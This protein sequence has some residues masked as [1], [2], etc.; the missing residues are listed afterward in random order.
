MKT[1]R[2]EKLFLLGICLCFCS[3]A[4]ANDT[5][6]DELFMWFA[7][8]SVEEAT[9]LAEQNPDTVEKDLE[10]AKELFAKAEIE[11]TTSNTEYLIPENTT[12]EVPNNE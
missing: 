6:D 12:S 9:L 11:T 1:S 8:L 4:S 7:E 3:A 10:S 5:S 2:L